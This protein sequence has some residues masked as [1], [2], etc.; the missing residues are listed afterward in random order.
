VADPGPILGTTAKEEIEA[1]IGGKLIP[2]L[3][4]DA[5]MS[6]PV[7]RGDMKI[8]VLQNAGLGADRLQRVRA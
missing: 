7:S 5:V 3:S 6:I 8:Y 4:P 2:S 1:K